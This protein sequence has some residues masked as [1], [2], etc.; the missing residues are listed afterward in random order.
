MEEEFVVLDES[1]PEETEG[2]EITIE[3]LH[4]NQTEMISILEEIRDSA[5]PALD[6][7]FSEYS[8]TEGLLLALLLVILLSW[9]RDMLREAF[10]W[11][12]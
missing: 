8:V 7:E 4:E 1:S 2:E 9:I 12:M 3:D 5:R 10:S 11:L 6:T